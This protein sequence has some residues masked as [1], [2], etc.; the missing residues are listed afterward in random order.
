[1]P[2]TWLTAGLVFV[3]V[4]MGT[5]SLALLAEWIRQRAQARTVVRQ[6]RDLA[7]EGVAQPGSE[8]LLRRA[9]ARAL[10]LEPVVARLP[11]LGDIEELL[12]RGGLGWGLQTFLL[13]SGGLA[14]AMGL[15]ALVLTQS[16][17]V[18]L[19]LAVIGG[20]LP[21]LHARRKA[22]ARMYKFEEQLPDAIDLIGRAI[23]A[24]HPINSGFKMVAEES[25]APIATEFRQVFE[26]QRFGLSFE[27]SMFALADRVPLV[28][29]RIFVVAVMIH[30]Q[31][32][33]NLAEVL[34]N[35][36]YIIRERFKLRR[37]LRVITAQG[38]LSGYVLAVLPVAVGFAIYLLNREYML[39]LFTHPI[40]R[41]LL[42][43][44]LF[45]QVVG[46]LW[47]RKI[48]DIEF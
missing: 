7:E 28:D 14:L 3:A 17:F 43:L 25:P 19:V 22:T 37:Q 32:G 33:G 40:G 12:R 31:V 29:V 8:D 27:D 36:A 5:V 11:R 2:A 35:L 4:A 23:R 34:D 48:V 18:A 45:F 20:F 39:T 16:F 9:E 44:A 6:L 24:G 42:I 10:W 15:G 41:L 26:E 46:Y 30:R 47:I 21:Y 1:M 38:R 13:I